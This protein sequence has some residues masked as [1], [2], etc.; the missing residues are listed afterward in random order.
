MSGQAPFRL[1]LVI[2]STAYAQRSTRTQLD[3]A[4]LAASVDF[5]LRL[6]FLGAAVLQLT[7]RGDMAAAQLPAGYRAWASLPGLFEHAGLVAFAEPEWLNRLHKNGLQSCLPVQASTAS[8]MRQ[9]WFE[10][11]KLL[12]L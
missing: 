1:G 10:C 9:D 12:T 3:V 6:Y 5:D 2:R 8:D 7:A 11:D 4:L